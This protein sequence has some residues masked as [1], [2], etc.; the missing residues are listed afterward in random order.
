MNQDRRL[1]SLILLCV[2]PFLL[3]C[4]EEPAGPDSTPSSRVFL[5]GVDGATWDIA[6]G[7]M[8]EGRMP[9]LSSLVESGLKAPLATMHPTLSP[10]LWT[11]VAT[12]KT[13][14]KHG[15]DGF[16]KTFDTG[17]G[18]DRTSIMHVTS[19]LRRTKALWNILG[20]LD[21]KVGF[22]GWWVT[23][24]AE[25]VN[26]Y[27]VSS[28]VPLS[29]TAT[30]DTPTKGTLV[31]SMSGQTWPPDLIDELRPLIRSAE[32]VTQ[33]E[34]ERFMTLEE[35]DFQMPVVEGFR[36]AYSADETYRAVARKLLTEDPDIDLVGLYFS[37][38]DVVSHRFWEFY[39]PEWYPKMTPKV[40]IEKFHTVIPSYYEYFD[41]ILGEILSFRRPGDTFVVLSDH[42]FGREGGHL[43]GDPPGILV[44]AGH[45]IQAGGDLRDPQLID[46]APTA[47]AALGLAT[48]KD[49]DGRVLVE[50]FTRDWKNSF[51]RDR[52]ASYDTEDW[53]EQ[54]A[55]ESEI[56][57]ELARRLKALGYID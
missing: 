1:Y 38:I 19:N 54:P 4:S 43:L 50:A 53:Q 20:D 29:Q 46:I 5:I 32:S 24:P 7:L 27:M 52:V 3:A 18:E 44:M 28:F 16:G 40:E 10:A 49:M 2:C 51:P 9:N 47:L 34:A 11:S 57:E 12:G 23:W 26:G 45:N 55:V 37:G 14:E 17:D 13:F 22:V 8:A 42:G 31:D 30:D 35:D 48:A 39:R 33:A 56:S 15:I 25:R 41:E 36:W 6:D 21:R